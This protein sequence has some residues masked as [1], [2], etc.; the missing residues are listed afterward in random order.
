MREVTKI[1]SADFIPLIFLQ[2]VPDGE[3]RIFLH[4]LS[5]ALGSPSAVLVWHICSRSSYNDL[6][7]IAF[8][9]RNKQEK[10]VDF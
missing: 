6:V 1:L 8:G 3:N 2:I 5:S 7:T 4:R 9:W 10:E